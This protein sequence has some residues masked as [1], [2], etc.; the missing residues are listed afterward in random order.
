M[1]VW[2]LT[3]LFR[4][5]YFATRVAANHRE[6]KA[7]PKIM[8]S[9]TPFPS[10]NVL[11]AP[12]PFLCWFQNAF[13]AK[14]LSNANASLCKAPQNIPVKS[15]YKHFKIGQSLPETSLDKKHPNTTR[16]WQ[17]VDH[18]TPQHL[19]T[20]KEY[21]ID[22]TGRQICQEIWFDPMVWLDWYAQIVLDI[23]NA[24]SRLLASTCRYQ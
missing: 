20:A 15:A 22:E 12:F 13:W 24:C 21:P 18:G 19:W 2:Q 1:N 9:D 5:W 23:L 7:P 6:E 11:R 4:A 17:T 8:H 3:K 14:R 16:I 10:P